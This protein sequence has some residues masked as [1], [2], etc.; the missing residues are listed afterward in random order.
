V[1]F[2]ER[3]RVAPRVDMDLNEA[4]GSYRQ[5]SECAA[6]GTIHAK[7]QGFQSDPSFS[8]TPLKVDVADR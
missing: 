7:H 6:A 5:M 1:T 3:P 8:L 2:P 4:T